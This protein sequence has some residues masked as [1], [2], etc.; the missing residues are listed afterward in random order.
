MP[1]TRS[2]AEAAS[3]T[4]TEVLADGLLRL[5]RAQPVI[6]GWDKAAAAMAVLG[7][8]REDLSEARERGGD[9]VRHDTPDIDGHDFERATRPEP[10]EPVAVPD[11]ADVTIMPGRTRRT[12]GKPV[13]VTR[14]MLHRPATRTRPVSDTG[15]LQCTRCRLWKDPGEFRLRTDRIGSGTRRSA[16]DECFNRDNRERYVSLRAKA[17][18]NA[19]GITLEILEGDEAAQLICVR[20]QEPLGLDDV[21]TTQD[22]ELAHVRCPSAVP[23]D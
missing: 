22:V 10:T 8:S 18:L 9:F 16:C 23:E 15:Q 5:L 13:A 2:A 1:T 7:L 11:P 12:A 20:C 19:V 21:E 6:L 3:L 4:A 14:T 17:Q